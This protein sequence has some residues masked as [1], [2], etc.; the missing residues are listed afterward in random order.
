MSPKS[1][2]PGSAVAPAAPAKPHAADKADP[3]ETAEAKARDRQAQGGKYGSTPVKPHQPPGD[4]GGA[5]D[6]G[7][8][9]GSGSSAKKGHWVEIELVDH[10]G[11]P[12]PGEAYRIE[13]PDGK[14][15]SGT[16][17][18]KGLARVDG[19]VDPGTCKITFP[20]LDKTAWSG[21]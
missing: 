4:G 20:R 17:D 9:D 19:I 15:V 8:S 13:L 16:L 3:V 1:G 10:R 21:G 12:V 6:D 14:G 2:S 18:E 11:K 7:A 5:S